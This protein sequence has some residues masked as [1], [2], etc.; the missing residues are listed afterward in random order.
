MDVTNIWYLEQISRGF[1][2]AEHLK[3]LFLPLSA[4]QKPIST[5]QYFPQHFPQYKIKFNLDTL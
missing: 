3:N 1:E 2:D 4:I 5:S